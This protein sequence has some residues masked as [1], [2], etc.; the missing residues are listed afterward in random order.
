M[1]VMNIVGIAYPFNGMSIADSVAR[2]PI[3]FIPAPY[4]TRIWPFIFTLL[5]LFTVWQLLM[6][7]RDLVVKLNIAFIVACFANGSWLVAFAYDSIWLTVVLVLLILISLLFIYVRLRIGFDVTIWN[8][9]SCC[10]DVN[11]DDSS[12][13][14][15][16]IKELVINY[17]LVQFPFSLYLGWITIISIA[18]F[19]IWL[20]KLG[21]TSNGLYWSLMMQVLAVDIGALVLLTSLDIAFCCAVVW[22]LAAITVEFNHFRIVF[23]GGVTCTGILSLLMVIA[24][25]Y[26][27]YRFF[28]Y[29]RTWKP[30]HA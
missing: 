1:V 28:V 8:P 11:V 27:S 30:V 13:E 3:S 16:S 9:W 18:N 6:R 12:R 5:G 15:Q 14:R 17:W 23:L 19:S 22:G 20:Y 24:L 7:N 29:V 25:I 10:F 26:R 2:Y 21:F 4:A